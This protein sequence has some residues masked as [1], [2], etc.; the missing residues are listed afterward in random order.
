MYKTMKYVDGVNRE[1]SYA[2]RRFG[3]Q[4]VVVYDNKDFFFIRSKS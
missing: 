1:T 2:M 3:E 4:K